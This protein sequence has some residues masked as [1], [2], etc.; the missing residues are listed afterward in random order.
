M[1]KKKGFTLL[2]LIITLALVLVVIGIAGMFYTS[3]KKTFKRAEIS[4]ELQQEAQKIE[5]ILFS[6]AT[7]SEGLEEYDNF[8]ISSVEKRYY[9]D[10]IDYDGNGKIQVN[11]IKFKFS[12]YY[13][14]LEMENE[15]LI[16]RKYNSLNFEINEDGFPQTLSENM[17]EITIRPVDFRM[18]KESGNFYEMKALELNIELKDIK[19]R[20]DAEYPFSLIVKFRNK[21]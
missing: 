13:Y 7:Q 10:V 21:K 8:K 12:N 2:E 3:V 16:A 5:E 1:K 6:L 17:K 14:S 15:K 9:K 19:G 11:K 4:S 20:T 18:N